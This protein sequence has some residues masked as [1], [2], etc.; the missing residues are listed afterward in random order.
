MFL[1]LW[2]TLVQ[3]FS[4]FQLF[5]LS[6]TEQAAV[7]CNQVQSPK[8]RAAEQIRHASVFLIIN[9]VHVMLLYMMQALD[10]YIFC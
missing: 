2:R 4:W 6:H 7:K 3:Y 5:L 9:H 10:T 8:Y 1:P